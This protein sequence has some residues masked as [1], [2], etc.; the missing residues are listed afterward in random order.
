M[1]KRDARRKSC[2]K[3]RIVMMHISPMPPAGLASPPLPRSRDSNSKS[4]RDN[5]S[6]HDHVDTVES[7]TPGT[8]HV[9]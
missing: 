6:S 7:E 1:L 8:F 2:S 3:R 4:L 5:T 9:P